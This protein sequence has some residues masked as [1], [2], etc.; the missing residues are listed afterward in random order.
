MRMPVMTKR[1][2]MNHLYPHPPP[3]QTL[4]MSDK[5]AVDAGA[6][7][8]AAGGLKKTETKVANTLPTAEDIAA[9]KAGK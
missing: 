2:E 8:A 6:V 5:V 7:A 4:I 1:K 3:K 9:E